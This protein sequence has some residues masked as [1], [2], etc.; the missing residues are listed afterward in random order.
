MPDGRRPDTSVHQNETLSFPSIVAGPHTALVFDNRDG[1]LIDEWMNGNDYGDFAEIALMCYWLDEKIVRAPNLVKTAQIYQEYED[2]PG[3]KISDLIV[4]RARLLEAE[5][6]AAM[7]TRAMAVTN[8]YHVTIVADVAD[9]LVFD[10]LTSLLIDS[11]LQSMH[12]SARLLVR[13]R[14][15]TSERLDGP[16]I[17]Q[18]PRERWLPEIVRRR[19]FGSRPKPDD[20]PNA[21]HHLH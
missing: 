17:Q 13:D 14:A 11:P 12:L 16:V 5:P 4:V 6:L 9:L 2:K 20:T 19:A 21:G 3:Q 1:T 8:V 18:L 7:I 10:R 15:P